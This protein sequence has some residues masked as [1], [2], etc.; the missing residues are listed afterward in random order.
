MPNYLRAFRDDSQKDGEPLRFIASTEDVARDGLII[1]AKG[2]QLENFQRNPVV[3][4]S[5]DYMGSRPPIGRAMVSVDGNHLVADVAFDLADPFAAEVERKYRAGFLN[6]VSVGWDTLESNGKRITKS[7]LL[8]ISAVNVPGDPGALIQRQARALAALNKTIDEILHAETDDGEA[9]WQRAARQMTRVFDVSAWTSERERREAF[10][11]AEKAYR[12]HGKKSPEWLERDYLHA[13][14]V[15]EVRGLFLEDELM[16]Y[17]EAFEA[18]AGAVLSARN[19][20]DLSQAIGLINSVLE[21]AKKEETPEPE[22]PR[23]ADDGSALKRALDLLN[24][25]FPKEK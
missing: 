16:L 12:K 11:S 7:E 15:D 9:E 10:N 20:D 4:W 23:A 13:L 8:D 3:L 19:R 14:D 24:Q 2:W 1:E 5:H 25:K 6:S 17:P 18:R 21:R 22:A